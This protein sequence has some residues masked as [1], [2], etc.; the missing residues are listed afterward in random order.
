MSIR[1]FT[2]LRQYANSRMGSW[3]DARGYAIM[4]KHRVPSAT[5]NM[6]ELGLAT[7]AD[8][9]QEPIRMVQVG[10]FDGDYFDPARPL[11]QSGVESVLLEPQPEAAGQLGER[12]KENAFIHI[13]NAALA[14]M[15]G[16]GTLYRPIGSGPSV[17]ATLLPE[18]A[19]EIGPCEEISVPLISPTDLLAKYGWLHLH[20][21]Q[22]D[23]EGYDLELLKLF[24]ARSIYPEIVN[25]ESFHLSASG[26]TELASLLTSAGYQWVD[27]NTWDT[28]AVRSS[29]LEAGNR[30]SQSHQPASAP[31]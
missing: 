14:P 11:I 12:Y 2:R 9:V 3:L 13:E 28:F 19:A 8:H 17:W 27:W 5:L 18:R 24:F 22:I 23:A 4:R 30:R 20:I 26:R 16:Q 31:R 29:L 1:I 6:L 21:L 10:A 25:I 7:L 15:S